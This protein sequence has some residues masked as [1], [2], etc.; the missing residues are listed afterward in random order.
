MSLKK[1]LPL[2]ESRWRRSERGRGQMGRRV[3]E[4]GQTSIGM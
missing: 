1:A 2:S 4:G 3:E